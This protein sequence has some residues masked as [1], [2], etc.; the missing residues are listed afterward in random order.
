ML[1][2][3]G[4][5]PRTP[6]GAILCFHSV[7]TPET[8]SRSDVHVSLAKFKSLIVAARGIGQLVPLRDLV[9]RHFAGRSTAGLISITADDAYASLLGETADFL[10]REAIPLTVF[11]VAQAAALG[12]AFWW[13]RVDDLFPYVSTSR[14]RAFEDA[15]GLP[16]EYRNRHLAPYGPLRP[17][18]QWILSAFTGR[19]PSELDRL[20]R[21]LEQETGTRTAHR[22]MTFEEL[23]SLAA[24]PSVDLGVHT[25]SHPVLPLL[26]DAEL[27]R[28]IAGS[29][30]ALR[31]RYANV[32]PILA[33]PFGLLD[34][35]SVR[36]ALDAGMTAS[37]TLA[38]TTLKQQC[39]GNDLPRFCMSQSE[40][41]LKLQLRLAS[42]FERFRRWRGGAVSRY[43]ALPSPTT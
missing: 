2:V 37:L 40:T 10:R 39:D 19:W 34:D 15:A 4:L 31:E 25:V 27:H 6:A 28:E 26:P 30:D 20:L 24:L 18:R 21:E 1:S 13:D 5:R 32:V 7:A 38:A 36:A 9:R 12:A 17:L 42:V 23:D 41:A 14:W 11:V 16:P 3:L 29:Y 35:R 8:P 22:S 43:P 33:M